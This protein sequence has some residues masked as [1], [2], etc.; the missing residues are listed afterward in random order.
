MKSW[1]LVF[2]AASLSGCIGIEP[3][4]QLT[5]Y[6]L[7]EL[8]PVAESNGYYTFGS[9][10]Y[11]GPLLNCAPHGAGL[12][13]DSIKSTGQ[14]KPCTYDK[15]N[16]TDT[17]YVQAKAAI[18]KEERQAELQERREAEQAR[19]QWRA[20]QRAAD[21]ASELS[22]QQAVLGGIAN[23]QQGVNNL[24][25]LDRQIAQQK[26]QAQQQ[27]RAAA[28][29]ASER[30]LSSRS[31][32]SKATAQVK[33][34]TR[35][36]AEIATKAAAASR[37]EHELAA[38]KATE[39]AT[40]KRTEEAIA[41]RAEEK[42]LKV[43][44]AAAAKEVVAAAK[45]DYLTKMAAGTK[46]YARNCPSGDGNYFLVGLLPKIK[47]ELV[48]CVDV[49]YEAICESNSQGN[50]GV[51]KNFVGAATDCFMGDAVTILPKPSCPI[52][53]VRVRVV[54]VRKCGE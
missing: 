23:M 10:R 3:P 29:Q 48:S 11:K 1:L 37:A 9:T 31:E 28:L 34:A 21:R 52:K 41:K 30:A 16:R 20:E 2:A 13:I 50:R 14:G 4:P 54:D 40:A 15:G 18:I 51:A 32:Q 44:E 25:V 8:K 53:Q 22:M 33:T 42:A 39:E 36:V 5:A 26:L 46:L 43:K 24:T 12:C 47:P 19:A 38:K 27:Q 6:N 17:A 35:P 49:H 45:K 7:T